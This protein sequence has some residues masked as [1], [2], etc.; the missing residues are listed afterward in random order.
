MK[1][2]YQNML[3]NA[4]EMIGKIPRVSTTGATATVA[5]YNRAYYDYAEACNY[6]GIITA[7]IKN[8]EMIEKNIRKYKNV[9]GYDIEEW[10]DM[11]DFYDEHIDKAYEDLKEF[12][13][14]RENYRWS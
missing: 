1:K 12:I 9:P 10:E 11:V 4:G 6:L 2:K 14:E 8:I 3:L 13:E 5:V 7:Y